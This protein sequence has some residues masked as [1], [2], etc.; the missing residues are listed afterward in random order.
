MRTLAMKKYL[1]ARQSDD[2]RRDIST[3]LQLSDGP[4]F[5]GDKIYYWTEGKSK[6]KSDGSHSG[7]WIKGKVISCDGSMIGIDLG[8]RI[9]KVNQSKLRKDH[10]PIE[11]VDVPLDPV[12]LSAEIMASPDRDP[13][14]DIQEK[15]ANQ[16]G[17]EG[18]NYSHFSWSPVMHGTVDFL[19]LFAGSAKLS[20]VATMNGLR[21]G[22]GRQKCMDIIER[23]KPKVIFMAPVCG[24]W[25]QMQNIN[26]QESADEKRR[27]YLPMLEFCARVAQYQID[28]GR[29]FIIENPM[30]SRIW[31]LKCLCRL[32]GQSN[33][34]W[35]S[36]DMCFFGMKDPRGYYYMK[37][38]S[39]MHNFGDGP[40]R[41]VFKKCLNRTGGA[42]HW[43]EY[44]FHVHHPLEGNAKGYGS[45][46]KLAQVYPCRFC[47]TLIRSMLPLGS[48]RSLMPAE[49]V[50]LIDCLDEF[51]E[52]ELDTLRNDLDYSQSMSEYEVFSTSAESKTP[53][54]V[55]DYYSKRTLN[56][57][58][59]LSAGYE[60]NPIDYDLHSDVSHIRQHFLSTMAFDNATVLRGT[61]NPLRVRY[62]QTN[63]VLVLW[64]KKDVSH[65]YVLSHPAANTTQLVDSQWSAIFFWNADGSTPIDI[66]IQPPTQADPPPGLPGPTPPIPPM[67]D[68]P[69]P[70][71]TGYQDEPMEPDVSMDDPAVPPNDPPDFPQQGGQ[72]KST[73]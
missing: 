35:D 24:P 12:A 27:K 23:Q 49:T 19:E 68:P 72:P 45:R 54:P 39:L 2:L 11:D 65:V 10:N 6:I 46:T 37:P 16:V 18:I 71:I 13:A 5:P 57:I 29:F 4:F 58:N 40:L 63:G 61:F 28:H 30:S 67:N 33:V 56:R 66:Q 64:K 34:T 15:D 25:S 31:H 26:S 50:F 17:P 51:S 62:R 32:L 41:P 7:K 55:I 42:E 53:L 73:S 38:T 48:L 36:L 43:G 69:E 22:H 21:V 52:K 60:Y 59:A 44:W 47:S 14:T 8:T 9:I 70:D 3:R 1:E 20:Q